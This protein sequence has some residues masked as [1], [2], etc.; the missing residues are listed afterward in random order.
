[1]TQQHWLHE[2]AMAL[3]VL[4]VVGA[5]QRLV[6]VT[7]LAKDVDPE[8]RGG[9]TL[10]EFA[11]AQQLAA[12]LGGRALISFAAN[13][14]H[15]ARRACVSVLE[16]EGFEVGE[17]DAEHAEHGERRIITAE[18]ATTAAAGRESKPSKK[19]PAARNAT[20]QKLCGQLRRF[21]RLLELIMLEAL[22]DLVK[23]S[24]RTLLAMLTW[25]EEDY[26]Q[27]PIRIH[28]ATT[29]ASGKHAHEEAA[30]EQQQQEEEE[31]GGSGGDEARGREGEEEEDVILAEEASFLRVDSHAPGTVAS[32]V[33]RMTGAFH[34]AVT[35]S[36]EHQAG[37][38]AKH[39]GA[40]SLRAVKK[41]LTQCFAAQFCHV[42]GQNLAGWVGT[43][44]SMATG[45]SAGDDCAGEGTATSSSL[46]S[47]SQIQ[48]QRYAWRPSLAGVDPRIAVV[49]NRQV[50]KFV[51]ML[52]R[53]LLRQGQAQ[54]HSTKKE[55]EGVEEEE[56]E[57]EDD[58]QQVDLMAQSAMS[59]G[60]N[61]FDAVAHLFAS[62][63]VERHRRLLQRRKVAQ[64]AALERQQT[65]QHTI[66]ASRAGD[67]ESGKGAGAG[68]GVAK[69][70]GPVF[71]V[72]LELRRRASNSVKFVAG[73]GERQRRQMRQHRKRRRRCKRQP[74]YCVIF[75]PTRE[76]MTKAVIG[77]VAGFET[78]MAAVS[79]LV[80][81]DEIKP[82]M[83][84]FDTSS[85]S[86]ESDDGLDDC[87]V[88]VYANEAGW[89][90]DGEGGESRD[91]FDQSPPSRRLH[92]FN[93]SKH[94]M[95]GSYSGS[96]VQSKCGTHTGGTSAFDGDF[97]W[98]L[99]GYSS[100]LHDGA[101]AA[102]SSS[103]LPAV[104][105]RLQADNVFDGLVHGL[106]GAVAVAY[107]RAATYA[108]TFDGLLQLHEYNTAFSNRLHPGPAL[109]A[110]NSADEDRFAD[111][112]MGGP[113]P[114]GL[115]VNVLEVTPAGRVD[116]WYRGYAIRHAQ[117]VWRLQARPE[118]SLADEESQFLD[119]V[120]EVEENKVDDEEYMYVSE[121]V[122]WWKETEAYTGA[123]NTD[124][125]KDDED[126]DE[127]QSSSSSST[128]SSFSG[129]EAD[130]K[131]QASSSSSS[132]SEDEDFETDYELE[133]PVAP[134]SATL[135]VGVELGQIRDIGIEPL[136]D[137]AVSRIGVG[138]TIR[139]RDRDTRFRDRA[140]SS[141]WSAKPGERD[142]VKDGARKRSD[143]TGGLFHGGG[144]GSPSMGRSKHIR[145]SNFFASASATPAP[146]STGA[147]AAVGGTVQPAEQHQSDP[148][149][150][151]FL[152]MISAVVHRLREQQSVVRSVRSHH[153]QAILCVSSVQLK[154]SLLG[155]PAHA[156]SASSCEEKLQMLL[157]T[158]FAEHA[159]AL[160][161][162]LRGHVEQ[163]GRSVSSLDRFG[164]HLLLVGNM[165]VWIRQLK[166]SHEHLKQM[167]ALVQTLGFATFSPNDNIIVD[168]GRGLEFGGRN[169]DQPAG[170]VVG[171]MSE[172]LQAHAQTQQREQ[173][174]YCLAQVMQ[175]GLAS[176][177]A[178]GGE[179]E[180]LDVL[181]QSSIEHTELDIRRFRTDLAS[182]LDG[183]RATLTL[184]QAKAEETEF[185]EAQTHA[186]VRG[187]LAAMAQASTKHRLKTLF[188]QKQQN[189]SVACKHFRGLGAEA[190]ALVE[191]EQLLLKWVALFNDRSKDRPE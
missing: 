90:G 32:F 190:E 188:L 70:R 84:A 77:T 69:R 17:F 143:I 153:D 146:M 24:T 155:T 168:D 61:D 15:I 108:T 135:A 187:K 14:R 78:A 179:L 56:T 167:A 40:L 133:A 71:S 111:T 20:R 142:L 177:E 180:R 41:V 130:D 102:C 66:A 114:L 113:C 50:A 99:G 150:G 171:S 173:A 39:G 87:G 147:A 21:V 4:E 176:V 109:A 2:P 131:G 67:S 122:E 31:R 183:V 8:Q 160:L 53:R 141:M 163:M 121:T 161:A 82:F 170:G 27:Q 162:R 93:S 68:K 36:M 92:R 88:K 25:S 3:A 189:A 34:E 140:L 127:L 165:S 96:A 117:A 156:V 43:A 30:G 37:T 181:V 42:G 85:E 7:S 91:T 72:S 29:T 63:V 134:G 12:D 105:R 10:N 182:R 116:E 178:A 28:T 23:R 44:S 22:H 46:S 164:E 62:R 125:D 149:E 64:K 172:R 65:D 1:M 57:D 33:Q 86:D 152:R 106:I 55:D 54:Q 107:S 60:A 16:A 49:V 110:I 186:S 184:L 74:S 144:G 9:L 103:V 11:R 19:L 138:I 151:D 18:M 76:E 48:E 174:R 119:D 129:S 38:A 166:D 191:E 124:A 115:S 75:S 157:P 59:V 97:L 51:R 112:N 83:H 139:S 132:S 126:V 118:H 100:A 137:E 128:S 120:E 123:W 136:H 95:H 26:N 169:G 80:L 52:L 148:F 159:S 101:M 175:S 185:G 145:G 89:D 98:R 104:H 13:C 58:L 6:A 158:I 73:G 5:C 81:H 35:R 47:A 45:D 94:V 79:G 154:N